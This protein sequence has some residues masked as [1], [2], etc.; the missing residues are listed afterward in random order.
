MKNALANLE[1]RDVGEHPCGDHALIVAEVVAFACAHDAFKT[2]DQVLG[3]RFP[4]HVAWNN[5]TT[6]M[7]FT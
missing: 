2:S 5:F 7:K 6:L 3:E 1:H 4:A